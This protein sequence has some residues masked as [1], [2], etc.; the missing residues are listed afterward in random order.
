MIISGK[1]C[2]IN[3]KGDRFVMA[4]NGKKLRRLSVVGKE[5]GGTKCL[6][7]VSRV[8][9][10]GMTFVEKSP[11]VLVRAHTKNHIR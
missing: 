3:V 2:I 10:G 1:R 11:N 7:P 5:S 8:D 4:S 6:N 9:I